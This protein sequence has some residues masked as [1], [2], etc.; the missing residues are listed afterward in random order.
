VATPTEEAGRAL[1]D[2][3]LSV[4]LDDRAPDHAVHGAPDRVVLSGRLRV[5]DSTGPAGVQTRNR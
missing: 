1:V 2:V 4:L 3:L 5:R